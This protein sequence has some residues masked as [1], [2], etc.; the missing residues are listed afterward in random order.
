MKRGD[1]HW[2][3]VAT[4]LFASAAAL[5]M[6]TPAAAQMVEDG[7]IMAVIVT[8]LSFFRVQ[9]LSFGQIV[10]RGTAGTVVVTPEGTRTA[11][12]T[13]TLTGSGYQPARF[14]G[15]GTYNRL[16]QIRLVSTST[17]QITGPGAPMTVSNFVI[18]STPNTNTLTTGWTQFRIGNPEGNFNFPVGGTLQVNAMQAPGTYTGTFTIQLQYL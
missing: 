1:F 5:A 7:D 12:G 6:P 13:L 17:I 15:R 4:A 14:A 3:C 16:V 10:A 9:D 2:R 8:P 11:T 18:G